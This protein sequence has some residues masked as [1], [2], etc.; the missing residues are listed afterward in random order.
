MN[1][2]PQKSISEKNWYIYPNGLKQMNNSSFLDSQDIMND[3]GYNEH[4][5]YL[6]YH[7]EHGMRIDTL[8][9]KL[10]DAVIIPV[11]ELF[12]NKLICIIRT[13]D[14][15]LTQEELIHQLLQEQGYRVSDNRE[16]F[17]MS[18]TDAIRVIQD[19]YDEVEC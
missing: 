14:K 13:D 17:K 5:Y 3:L 8:Y 12:T 10:T 18:P 9:T 16:F 7:D 2:A 1:I 6:S 11:W 15:L 19:Y 4:E